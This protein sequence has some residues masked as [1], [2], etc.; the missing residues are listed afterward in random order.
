MELFEPTFDPLTLHWYEG[1]PPLTG[2]AV[3][4]TEDPAQEGFD[5]AIMDTLAG[6]FEFTV[7]VTVLDVAGLPVAQV[8]FDV[9]THVTASLFEGM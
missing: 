5:D 2:V 7:I 6:R 3:K 4:V 8:L 1:A 9:K